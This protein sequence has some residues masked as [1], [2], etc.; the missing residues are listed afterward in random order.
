MIEL[1]RR[2][3]VMCM[4]RIVLFSVVEQENW[5][6]GINS[7]SIIILMRRVQKTTSLTIYQ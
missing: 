4:C 3:F 1:V 5:V 7:S 2:A 6:F